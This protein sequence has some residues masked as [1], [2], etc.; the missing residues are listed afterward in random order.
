ME[1]ADTIKSTVGAY[2]E[3]NDLQENDLAVILQLDFDDECND[4]R[5]DYTITSHEERPMEIDTGFWYDSLAEAWENYL[6][7]IAEINQEY[8]EADIRNAH[9]GNYKGGKIGGNPVMSIPDA[10]GS[11]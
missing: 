8:S 3:A 9:P 4:F 11:L 1:D 5:I 10:D 6:D 2:L 7:Q